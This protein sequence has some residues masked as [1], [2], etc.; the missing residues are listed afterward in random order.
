MLSVSWQYY[1][2][3]GCSSTNIP[4]KFLLRLRIRKHFCKT[5]GTSVI[6]SPL[7]PLSLSLWLCT[8]IDNELDCNSKVTDYHL[9]NKKV[10]HDDAINLSTN[11]GSIKEGGDIVLYIVL[12]PKL[13]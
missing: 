1:K 4:L 3:P 2:V 8:D 13:V 7:S 6:K 9:E 11:E 12:V 10:W 5:L